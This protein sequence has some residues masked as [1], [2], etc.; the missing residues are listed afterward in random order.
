[1]AI[2]KPRP[3]H[4]TEHSSLKSTALAPGSGPEYESS[5]ALALKY[6]RS[7]LCGGPPAPFA[8]VVIE[9]ACQQWDPR[10]NCRVLGHPALYTRTP[11]YTQPFPPLRSKR[12][13]NYG[14]YGYFPK[15]PAAAPTH[16][17]GTKRQFKYLSPILVVVVVNFDVVLVL[18]A[19]VA[20]QAL[21]DKPPAGSFRQTSFGICS[22]PPSPPPIL[23]SQCP[24][25]PSSQLFRGGGEHD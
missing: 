21:N 24:W 13:P 9:Q 12:D 18:Y 22:S 8:T 20:Q 19:P 6:A 16:Q 10:G 4:E 1:M 15:D 17:L 3:E 25:G 7:A 11:R 5:A 23:L 14:G 2:V